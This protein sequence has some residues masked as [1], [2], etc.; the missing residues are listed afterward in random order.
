MSNL[1]SLGIRCSGELWSP[2][3]SAKLQD[4]KGRIQSHIHE[5][6]YPC[7]IMSITS[8]LCNLDWEFQVPRL[9][10]RLKPVAYWEPHFLPAKINPDTS[11][12][13]LT[14]PRC[15]GMVQT[16]N[17][18]TGWLSHCGSCSGGLFSSQI[19]KLLFSLFHMW[20]SLPAAMFLTLLANGLS[21][22][23]NHWPW[24]F[25]NFGVPG[26]SQAT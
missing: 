24:S 14:V 5:P 11:H 18:V 21:Q 13:F 25:S 1:L 17:P 15:R 9:E 7:G 6:N 3:G 8:Y 12:H 26:Q 23:H 10:N 20:T 22:G 4:Q 19:P 2:L 16:L